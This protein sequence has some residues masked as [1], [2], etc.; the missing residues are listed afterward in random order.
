MIF[1]DLKGSGK[2]FQIQ[3]PMLEE[4][5]DDLVQN[6]STRKNE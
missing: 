3:D 6:S 2:K 5:L 4:M 1:W